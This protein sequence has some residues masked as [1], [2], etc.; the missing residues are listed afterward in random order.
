MQMRASYHIGGSII[1]LGFHLYDMISAITPQS[2]VN[3]LAY[4]A[5]VLGGSY[6]GVSRLRTASMRLLSLRNFLFLFLRVFACVM[7][8]AAAA[9]LAL[10][11]DA[12][13]RYDVY[14]SARS[15]ERH[16]ELA[17]TEDY[18]ALR[19]RSDT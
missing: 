17:E 12:R 1:S 6:N 4:L 3:V 14:A 5:T 7:T 19:Q 9:A 10:A 15:A 8:T 11:K 16:R 13:E 18:L 2:S